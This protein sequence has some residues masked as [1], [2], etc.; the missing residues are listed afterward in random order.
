MAADTGEIREILR[1]CNEHGVAV[2]PYGAGTSVEGHLDSTR[3]GSLML[4]VS[5]MDQVPS[6]PKALLPYM[7]L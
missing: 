1:L 4:D 7:D 3:E 6:P 5:R 2:V